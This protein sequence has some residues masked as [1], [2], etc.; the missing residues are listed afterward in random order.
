MGNSDFGSSCLRL[1]TGIEFEGFVGKFVFL[2][3]VDS[4]VDIDSF[5]GFVGVLVASLIVAHVADLQSEIVVVLDVG[6]VFAVGVVGSFVLGAMG[7]R[8]TDI[9]VVTSLL[10]SAENSLLYSNLDLNC[11]GQACPLLGMDCLFGYPLVVLGCSLIGWHVTDGLLHS[12]LVVLSMT[13]P[14]K[15]LH[16]YRFDH[17]IIYNSFFYIF[18]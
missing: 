3:S 2:P 7:D 16:S 5:G 17:D 8:M 1:G 12:C 10:G 4:A 9:R 14:E 18:A 6:I 11:M 15:N 13:G